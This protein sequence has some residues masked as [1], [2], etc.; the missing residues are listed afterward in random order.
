MYACSPQPKDP[1]PSIP[2]KRK[3][4]IQLRVIANQVSFPKAKPSVW[5]AESHKSIHPAPIGNHDRW[6]K[7]WKQENSIDRRHS[8]EV[9]KSAKVGTSPLKLHKRRF[10]QRRKQRM[11]EI[12]MSGW[13]MQPLMPLCDA[14]KTKRRRRSVSHFWYPSC[15][16]A[17][18][19]LSVIAPEIVKIGNRKIECEEIKSLARSSS[20]SR[21]LYVYRSRLKWCRYNGEIHDELWY[22]RRGLWWW[23]IGGCFQLCG[24]EILVTWECG[25]KPSGQWSS[26]RQRYR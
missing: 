11:K 21:K 12:L 8:P 23:L 5:K 9:K 18:L 14:K 26:R 13:L 15:I 25:W 3:N 24:K 1:I 19:F 2:R 6:P 16:Y 7:N 20:D 10:I 22:R 17:S 4:S